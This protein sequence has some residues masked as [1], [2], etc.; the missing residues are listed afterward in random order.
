MSKPVRLNFLAIS[1]TPEYPASDQ[2]GAAAEFAS[3]FGD[4]RIARALMTL[5]VELADHEADDLTTADLGRAIRNVPVLKPLMRTEHPRTDLATT[6]EITGNG[7]ADLA[8]AIRAGATA[9]L[10]IYDQASDDLGDTAVIA[11]CDW[12]AGGPCTCGHHG[13]DERPTIKE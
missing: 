4:Y 13:E 1:G 2:A 12:S 11:V 10:P 8:A 5:A 7:D 6:S 9:R 3:Q